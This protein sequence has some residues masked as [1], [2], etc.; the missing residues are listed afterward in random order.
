MSE[1]RNT[2]VKQF[3]AEETMTDE[4][5]MLAV[6]Q[7]LLGCKAGLTSVPETATQ[8]FRGRPL[9]PPPSNLWRQS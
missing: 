9:C 4:Q 2:D 8:A 3:E 1:A 6:I 7:A 5:T